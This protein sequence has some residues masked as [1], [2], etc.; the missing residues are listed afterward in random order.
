NLVGTLEAEPG[1]LIQLDIV[2]GN[3]FVVVEDVYGFTFPF[4]Y[5]T[6]AVSFFNEGVIFQENSWLSYDS[7]ILSLSVNDPDAGIINTAVSRTN[8]ESISGY[9]EIGKLNFVVVEDV[10]G[11]FDTYEGDPG[12]TA[13]E[14]V[15][16]FG[17]GGKSAIAMNGAG[18]LDAV[19]VNPHQ[20]TVKRRSPTDASAFSP[21][22]AT[23]YLDGKLQV[24]P[25]PTADRLSVHLNGQQ[26]FTAL[27]LTDL[28]GRI[29]LTES[30]LD[31]NHREL[32]LGQVPNGI[33]TLT[34]TTEAGVVNR[35]VEV[36]R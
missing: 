32:L 25:N 28:T 26:R 22:A 27:R 11:F 33:Y 1:D 35:K 2:A 23:D 24:Y 19:R 4:T 36:L 17:S 29:V 15:L 18:H 21:A 9:G 8:G 16:T 10:Y 20:V 5:D 12:F 13:E 7:P 14:Q 30:G 34:L 31:T 6:D 3:S